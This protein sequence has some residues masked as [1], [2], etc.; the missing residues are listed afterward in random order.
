MA[1]WHLDELRGTLERKGWKIT[2]LPG[3]D[4][5]LSATWSLNR[6]AQSPEAF[7]DFEGLDDMKTLPIVESYA[8]SERGKPNSLYFGR[9]GERHS[10]TRESWKAELEVFVRAIDGVRTEDQ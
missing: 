1:Q 8:C 7:I 2:E 6:S 10:R 4:Y 3:D 9:R 5:R